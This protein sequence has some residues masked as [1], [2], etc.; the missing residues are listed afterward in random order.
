MDGTVMQKMRK[1]DAEAKISQQVRR[2]GGAI[3]AISTTVGYVTT[4]NSK[5]I[6]FKAKIL[7]TRT[8]KIAA[9]YMAIYSQVCIRGAIVIVIVIATTFSMLRK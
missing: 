4:P 2:D 7:T 1:M 9:N 8:V 5:I 6:G 3:Y